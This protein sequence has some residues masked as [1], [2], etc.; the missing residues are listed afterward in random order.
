M[1]LSMLIIYVKIIITSDIETES[2]DISIQDAG[3]SC[4]Y[5]NI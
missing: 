1:S 2:I 5:M 3:I 4:L